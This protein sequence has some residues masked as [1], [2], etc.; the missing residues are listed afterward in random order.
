MI[1][2]QERE[3][4]FD[5]SVV[6]GLESKDKFS[7]IRELVGKSPVFRKLKKPSE[8]IN[9]IYQREQ[10]KTTGFGH[11]IAVAHGKVA[12]INRITVALGISREGIAYNSADGKPVHLLFLIASPPDKSGAYLKTL[13]SLMV[14]MRDED[15]RNHIIHSKSEGEAAALLN[16]SFKKHHL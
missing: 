6:S 4:Q 14:M 12:S 10:E 15:F 1:F 11:G 9:A 7:A 13:A 3:I 8:F 16:K 2:R 5:N